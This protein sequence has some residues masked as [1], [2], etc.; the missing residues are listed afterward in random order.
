[1]DQPPAPPTLAVREDRI[2]NA[3]AEAVSAAAPLA[4]LAWAEIRPRGW[5]EAVP[6]PRAF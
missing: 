4:V 6:A 1:V 2:L 5:P 3:A